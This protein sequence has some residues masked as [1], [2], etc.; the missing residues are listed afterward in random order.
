MAVAHSEPIG[1]ALESRMCV[2]KE[3]TLSLLRPEYELGPLHNVICLIV[4]DAAIC[5]LLLGRNA[6]PSA[7]QMMQASGTLI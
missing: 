6:Q 4:Q 2:W 1:P 3:Q 5:I 7:V